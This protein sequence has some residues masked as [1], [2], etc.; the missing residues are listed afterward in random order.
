MEYLVS[1]EV[2]VNDKHLIEHYGISK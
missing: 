2:G 1:D